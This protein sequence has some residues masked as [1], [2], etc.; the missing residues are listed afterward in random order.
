MNFE[1]DFEEL[2]AQMTPVNVGKFVMGTIISLG[3]T[4]A[5]VALM[6]SPLH[7]AKGITKLMMNLGIF[8]LGCKAGDIAEKYFNETMDETVKAFNEAKEET[9]DGTAAKQQP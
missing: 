6:K 8:V 1:K 7:S 9:P 5:V 2:K 3:A 4:A